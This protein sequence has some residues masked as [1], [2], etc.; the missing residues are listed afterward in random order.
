M[1]KFQIGNTYTTR[2]ACDHDCIFEFTIVK[3]SEKFITFTNRHGQQ[4]RAGVFQIDQVE[5]C[6]PTGRYSMAPIISAN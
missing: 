2:S 5:H 1:T 3:R 6:F 4:S